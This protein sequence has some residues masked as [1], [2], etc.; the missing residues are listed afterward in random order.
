MGGRLRTEVYLI[1]KLF[2]SFYKVPLFEGKK[3]YHLKFRENIFASGLP[4]SLL[5]KEPLSSSRELCF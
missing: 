1:L 4:L 3:G 5:Q 2:F